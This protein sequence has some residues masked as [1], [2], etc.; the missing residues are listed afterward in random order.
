MQPREYQLQAVNEVMLLW[1]SGIKSVLLVAPTGSGKT[2]MASLAVRRALDANADVVSLAHRRELIEQMC[3]RFDEA[4]PI[5]P[6]MPE[7]PTAAVQVGTVQTLLARGHRPEA[8]LIVVDEA[9]HYPKDSKWNSFL[10]AYPN[11]RILGLTATPERADGQPLGDVFE[12]MVVAA[13]YSE[14]LRDGY[15]APCDIYSVDEAMGSNRLATS[16]VA[17]YNQYTPNTQAICFVSSRRDAKKVCDDYIGSGI[18]AA[19]ID[20]GTSHKD[21]GRATALF[22]AEIIKVLVNVYTLTEGVDLPVAETAI[23]ARNV[24]H[25]ST[26]LQMVGRVLRTSKNKER[27]TLID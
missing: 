4:G 8:Q 5:C 23:I 12:E 6:G 16:P 21:R 22:R 27:A 9:H 19:V 14:L 10:D 25:A 2:L 1:K 17:A 24:G 3:S 18:N 15:I 26:Y 7:D 13:N 20:A 11:A